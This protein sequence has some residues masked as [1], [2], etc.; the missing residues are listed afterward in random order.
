[1]RFVLNSPVVTAYGSY[2]FDGPLSLDAARRFAA[3]GMQSAVGH[4][5]TAS[6]LSRCLRV[7]VPCRR[8]VVRMAPGDQALVFRLLD[9]QTEGHVLD[10]DSLA[11]LPH[12]FGL[13][14]RSS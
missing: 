12:E 8:V 10:A 1:M 13:L 3:Q 5:A 11:A 4:S 6:L 7:T 14:T 2:R 9:R